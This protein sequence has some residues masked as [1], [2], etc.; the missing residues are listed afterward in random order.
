MM[1]VQ[2]KDIA[3][4]FSE[5]ISGLNGFMWVIRMVGRL[6]AGFIADLV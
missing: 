5:T 4:H 2:I 3:T 1:Y 6:A